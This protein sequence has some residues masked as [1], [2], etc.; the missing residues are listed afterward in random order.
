MT[1]SHLRA[2]GLAAAAAATLSFLLATPAS[3]TQCCVTETMYIYYSNA[4][5]STVVGEYYQEGLC[6]RNWGTTSPYV[7]TQTRQCPI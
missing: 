4:S 3:A 6:G 5:H 1:R 7:V 2:T